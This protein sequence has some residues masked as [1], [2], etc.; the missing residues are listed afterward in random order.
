MVVVEVV[1]VVKVVKVV[2]VVAVAT[3]HLQ[4]GLGRFLAERDQ[5]LDPVALDDEP[6]VV[7]RHEQVGDGR[8]REPAH[9]QR[10]RRVAR[11]EVR[12]ER[13]HR[14]H[15]DGLD[16]RVG[17]AEGD[18][19]AERRRRLEV[20]VGDA[21]PVLHLDVGRADQRLRDEGGGP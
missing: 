3:R 10:R 1:E 15:V 14:R 18:E 7:R 20:A 13:R 17:G 5:R 19:R 9:R 11:A 16:R 8:R 4:L 2:K 6:L 12:D 21:R